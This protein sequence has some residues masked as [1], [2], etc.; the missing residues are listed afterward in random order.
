MAKGGKGD[1][2]M[3][4]ELAWGDADEALQHSTRGHD[5]AT[6]EGGSQRQHTRGHDEGTC[7]GGRRDTTWGRDR[8]SH[9]G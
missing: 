8:V 5:E 3:R 1:V 4:L 9:Q 2:S 7:E 6:H